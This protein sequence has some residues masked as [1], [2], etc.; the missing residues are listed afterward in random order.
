[1]EITSDDIKAAYGKLAPWPD[2]RSGRQWRVPVPVALPF[3]TDEPIQELQS[4]FVIEF[5]A[6][7]VKNPVTGLSG[8][9]IYGRHDQLKVFCDFIPIAEVRFDVLQD[10]QKVGTVP[11]NFDPTKIKSKSYMYSPRA[12]DFQR[13]RDRWIAASSLGLGD[14]GAVPGFMFER[15][16]LWTC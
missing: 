11:G 4:V 6:F 12:G 13:D 10:G 16:S 3:V 7:T 15:S 2:W 1:M 5:Q 9:E 14:L 8:W